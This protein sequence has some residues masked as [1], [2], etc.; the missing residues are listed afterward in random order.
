MILNK[1]CYLPSEPIIGSV[2]ITKYPDI[3]RI[4]ISI[5]MCKVYDWYDASFNMKVEATVSNNVLSFILPNSFD[6]GLYAVISI[7]IKDTVV[8]GKANDNE[9]CETVF[10]ISEKSINALS[11]YRKILKERDSYISKPKFRIEDKS[12]SSYDVFLFIKNLDISYNAYYD[13]IQVYPYDYLRCTSEIEYINEFIQK[14]TNI[15]IVVNQEYFEKLVPSAVFVINNIMAYDYEEAEEYAINEAEKLNSIFTVL[16]HSHGTI[17]ATLTNGKKERKY[18]T[19]IL[20]TRY[21]GNLLHLAENGFNIRHY[22]KY[23]SESDSYIFVYLKLLRDAQNENER[24]LKYYRYWNILE[25]LAMRKDYR[26]NILTDWQGNIVK[27]K[28]G[29]CTIGDQ[30]LNNVFE[31]VRQNFS[32]IDGTTFVQGLPNISTPK[33]FI[34]VCYQRRNC[35]AHWGSCNNTDSSICSAKENHKKKCKESNIVDCSK[36][37]GFRDAILRKLQDVTFQIVLKELQN[38][39]GSSFRST[40]LIDNIIDNS[41]NDKL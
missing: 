36:P 26:N 19:T 16:L 33:E 9:N 24:M 14:N 5:Q 25:G 10:L 2:L 8:Y 34:S 27:S 39:A 22:F 30:K 12:A 40:T 41:P 6:K 20:D 37:E 11:L 18:K 35:C 4:D 28:R 13:T 38:L 32:N 7:T 31:L 23:I 17:F 1:C 3:E 29:I 15:N 21:K